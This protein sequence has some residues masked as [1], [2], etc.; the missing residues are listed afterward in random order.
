MKK[1]FTIHVSMPSSKYTV[2]IEADSMS[3]KQGRINFWMDAPSDT[4]FQ[5]EL[6]STYPEKYTTIEKIERL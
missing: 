2:I 4:R 1:K 3:L 6:L 5:K